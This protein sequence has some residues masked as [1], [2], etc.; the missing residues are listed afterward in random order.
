MWQ[1]L[2]DWDI[3]AASELIA[4]YQEPSVLT[5]ASPYVPGLHFI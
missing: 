1:A 3:L 2:L 4:V 5:A